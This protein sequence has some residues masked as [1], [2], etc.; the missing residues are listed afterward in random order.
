L[1]EKYLLAEKPAEK[2]HQFFVSD[3][4]DSFEQSA[5]HFFGEK[6]RLIEVTL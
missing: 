3:Y 2:V 5:Q 1:S 6:I 4:T